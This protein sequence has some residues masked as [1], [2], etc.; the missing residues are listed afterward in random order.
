MGT[1]L[2]LI[3]KIIKYQ[4]VYDRLFKTMNELQPGGG[5]TLNEAAKKPSL[6]GGYNYVRNT[7]VKPWLSLTLLAFAAGASMAVIFT[8]STNLHLTAEAS[9][10]ISH[11]KAS[12]ESQGKVSPE[13]IFIGS[14]NSGPDIVTYAGVPTELRGEAINPYGMIGKYQWDFDGDGKADW[15]SS[16]TAVLGSPPF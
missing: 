5:Q 3:I 11:T 7:H 15:E 13:Q 16:A 6:K 1:C 8:A 14:A 12:A 4:A 9:A 10:T 2:G